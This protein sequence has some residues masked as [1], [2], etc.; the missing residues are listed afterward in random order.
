MRTSPAPACGSGS[1]TTCRTSGPPHV[2]TP[3][4]F[5]IVSS[6]PLA[7]PLTHEP[8]REEG[9]HGLC[10]SVIQRLGSLALCNG[11]DNRA[12]WPLSRRLGDHLCH[13]VGHLLGSG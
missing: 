13:C 12:Q 11:R 5:I 7:L 8:R 6:L 2:V 10:G 3:I 9:V 4:A 1:S